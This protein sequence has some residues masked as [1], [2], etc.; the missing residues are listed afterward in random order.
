MGPEGEIVNKAEYPNHV[1]SYDFVEDYCM[2][3]RG[4]L[5]ARCYGIII[6]KSGKGS[7]LTYC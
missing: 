5:T 4:R 1:W 6:Y 3:P 7:E 2:V